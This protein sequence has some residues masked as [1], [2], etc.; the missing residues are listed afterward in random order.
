MSIDGQWDNVPSDW[1]DPDFDTGRGVS[2][3]EWKSY[4]DSEVQECWGAMPDGLKQAL[5]QNFNNIAD[6]EEWD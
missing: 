1:S 6:R 4:V 3:H 2:V 5:A